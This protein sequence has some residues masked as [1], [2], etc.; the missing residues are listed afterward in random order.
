M[1]PIDWI[2]ACGALSSGLWCC[3]Q[4][5][6]W[7]HT[8]HVPM[9]TLSTLYQVSQAHAVCDMHIDPVPYAGSGMWG[10]FVSLSSS[11]LGHMLLI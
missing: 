3:S 5:L 1:Q 10:C 6:D 11:Q 7:T 9:W 2:P 4:V 8:K